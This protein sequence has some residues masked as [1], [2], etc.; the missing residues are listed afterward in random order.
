VR[1]R[2]LLALGLVFIV[3][4]SWGC[5]AVSRN[6]SSSFDDT[7]NSITGP[8][9]FNI[10]AWE[11][12]TLLREIGQRVTDP[13]PDSAL[14]SQSVVNYFSDVA[15]LNNLKSGLGAVQAKQIQGDIDHYEA[16]IKEAESQ[17]ASLKPIV[18]QTIAS[19]IARTLAEQGIYNPFNNDWLQ[20]P[21][22]PVS[23]KLEKPLNVLVISPR[24]RIERIRDIVIKPDLNTSQMVELESSVEGLIVS[25]LVVQIGGTGATYPSFV[26]D[27][28]DLRFTVDAAVEEW[29][30]QYLAFK[31]LGFRY[32]LDLLRIS[33]KA[34]IPTIN[35]TVAGIAS[36][37]IGSMV[38]HQ[39][40]AQ[41]QPAE[42]GEGGQAAGADFVAAMREIRLNVNL[43]LAE[44]QIDRA[45]KYMEDQR[46]ML[47]AK[48]YNI[49][50]LNQAYF[51]FYGSYAH[52]P[53]SIDPI[54]DQVRLLRK[55][56]LSLKDFLDTAANITG[57]QDLQNLVSLYGG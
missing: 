53:T 17:I 18:E 41:Y 14:N 13:Q 11:F 15:L 38:Y 56:S 36:K 54:G 44:G 1:I 22:P 3:L 34:D 16:R 39:F 51:A 42:T 12:N 28:A 50:K 30:H 47:N 5:V 27:N 24:D 4:G 33:P 35:E 48:G 7:L 8:Y 32:V 23:F 20:L 9:S 2:W 57:S 21:F 25:A 31:P 29:L 26:T 46:Q 52:S 49:R 37:E 10:A 19:Q 43:F 40:Y 6:A 55:H 45:E